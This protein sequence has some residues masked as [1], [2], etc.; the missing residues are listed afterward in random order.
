MTWTGV[1]E[2][3]TLPARDRTP[4]SERC[5]SRPPRRSDPANANAVGGGDPGGVAAGVNVTV[6][7]DG[8][9][10]RLPAHGKCVGLQP[11][12]SRDTNAERFGARLG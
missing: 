8:T 7:A 9:L 10:F 2:S 5:A 12:A 3:R 6:V 4:R 1:A 11:A